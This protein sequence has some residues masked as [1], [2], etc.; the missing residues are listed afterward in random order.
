MAAP[1]VVPDSVIPNRT[2]NEN[3]APMAH[4]TRLCAFKTRKQHARQRRAK[5]T[6]AQNGVIMVLR[7]AAG[8]NDSQ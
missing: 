8:G 1:G 5:A 6:L 2:G 4:S 7:S 3:A